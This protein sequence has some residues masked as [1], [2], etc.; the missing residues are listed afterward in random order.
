MC[1]I[2][3]ENDYW[4]LPHDLGVACCLPP[5]VKTKNSE[6]FEKKLKLHYLAFAI[7]LLESRI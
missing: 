3:A 7:F 4:I 5:A 1:H 2:I 6:K